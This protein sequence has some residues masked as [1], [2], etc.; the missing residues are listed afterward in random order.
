MFQRIIDFVKKSFPY[1]SKDK[2]S[3]TQLNQKLLKDLKGKK[4]P[5][6]RQIKHIRRVFSP[7]EKKLFNVAIIL[8]LIGLAWGGVVW[9][10]DYRT[11]VPAV[12]GK[13]VEGVVGSPQLINPLFSS[14]NS[15]DKDI[16]SLVY[17][18]LMRYD[19]DQKLVTDLAK[20]YQIS[21]D[22]KTF[23]FELRKGVTWH[24]GKKFTAEDVIFTYNKIKDK[25]INS[26]EYVTFKDVQVDKLGK[27]KVRFELGKSY[28]GFLHNLT[29]GV[30]PKHIWQGI[31]PQRIRLT[32]KNLQPIGTGPYQFKKL[33]KDNTGYI[34]K[35]TLER[36]DKFY[37]KPPYIQSLVFRFYRNYSGNEGVIQEIK[38]QAID[39]LRF[40]PPRKRGEIDKKSIKIHKLKQPQYTALFFNL[41]QNKFL[42]NEKVRKAVSLAIDKQRILQEALKG[43]GEVIS[44]PILSMFGDYKNATS[45][46]FNV[47]KANSLLDEEFDKIEKDKYKELRKISLIKEKNIDNTASTNT[48]ESYYKES[49][50]IIEEEYTGEPGDYEKSVVI[51]SRSNST[52][53]RQVTLNLQGNPG[54]QIV[55]SNDTDF[56]N[57][58]TREFQK[59]IKWD[60]TPGDGKKWVFVKFKGEDEKVVYDSIQLVDQFLSEKEY[61]EMEIEPNKKKINSIKEQIKEELDSPQ[62]FYRV[63]EEDEILS[64][65]I[66]TLDTE[67]YKQ[68]AKLIKSFLSEIGVKV[69]LRFLSPRMLSQKAVEDRDYDS[70]LYGVVVGASGDQYPFWHSSQT[71]SPGLN[72][73]QYESN[74]VDEIL[75]KVRSATTSKK[76]KEGYMQLQEQISKDKP[77]VFLYTPY[78]NY[79]QSNKIKGFDLN[80][81]YS[82]ENRFSGIVDWYTET[83]TDWSLPLSL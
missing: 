31:T 2:S 32:Q 83:E 42:K 69:D 36:N 3:S 52:T 27:Y 62:T 5:S 70:L 73:S 1:F 53:E 40:V 17:S 20:D 16:S 60:L 37:R 4:V 48:L 19:S 66:T 44:D 58:K 29:L 54:D 82:T 79:A 30:I 13:Y 22:G 68:S 56:E 61:M 55:I 6:W 9:T 7:Q 15:V 81:I 18:G 34:Y 11:Q 21:N 41:K 77:A 65:G 74:N 76:V 78:Y 25:K 59:N 38:E 67:E 72:L 33:A 75:S 49:D 51:N 64:F 35:Y 63:G 28:P 8:L 14:L 24:D 57:N 45:T 39:G 47:K 43:Q 23:T 71:E 12:G 46:K 80:S 10:K 50:P 26:P